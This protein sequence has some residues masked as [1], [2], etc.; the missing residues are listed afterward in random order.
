MKTVHRTGGHGV[1]IALLIVLGMMLPATSARA[2]INPW[3]ATS[4]YDPSKWDTAGPYTGTP[5][6]HPP[7][8]TPGQEWGVFSTG[9]WRTTPALTGSWGGPRDDL[10]KRYGVSLLGG[11]FG[12][13]A[14]NPSGGQEHGVSFKGDFGLALFGDLKRL[15]GWQGGFFATS[16]SFKNPGKSLTN[17]YIDNQFPVQVTNG[18]VDGAAR[19][20]HLALGQ[21]FWDDKAEIVAGRLITGEDF[22]SV[23]L[24]CTSLNQAICANPIVA[25]QSISFPTYPFAVWGA[26]FKVKPH[27]NWYAQVGS[28]LV[29]DDFRDSGFYGVKFSAPD[30]S[31]MLTLGEAGYLV[32]NLA[33]KKGRPGVYKVGGYHDGERLQ[34]L[35]TGDDARGTWG[36]YALGQQML[37]SEDQKYS[38]GLSAFGALSYAPPDRNN[39]SFMAA[40][41]LSYQGL[42][43]GRPADRLSFIG[44][45]GY[46]GDDLDQATSDNQNQ[47]FEGLLELNYQYQLAPWAFVKPDVQYIINPDGR[48]DIDNAL[49]LGFAVGMTF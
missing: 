30:G 39:V 3:I 36:V 18:D 9:K 31:G 23:P 37:F 13:F 41:G 20:V 44:A 29:F 25:N 5:W 28:Y 33:G 34:D 7:L 16:F 1:W 15:L 21:V 49:V 40:G 19:L 14:S 35:S 17:D 12:Q 8:W 46:F 22:A 38:Q 27:S 48:D 26:R 24:A 2:D 11:Y 42:F 32:G 6:M 43:P 4:L 47:T 10:L 45:Y